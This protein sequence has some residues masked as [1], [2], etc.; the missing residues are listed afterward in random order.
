MDRLRKSPGR[1]LQQPNIEITHQSVTR[2]A[3]G[4]I[5]A[6]EHLEEQGFVVF[7]NALSTDETATALELLWDYLE[8]LETGVDRNDVAIWDDTHWPTATL[9]G[10]LTL[11]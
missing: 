3:V 6:K 9:A 11:L 1:N 10:F 4:D 8:E 5:H 7:A 2:F